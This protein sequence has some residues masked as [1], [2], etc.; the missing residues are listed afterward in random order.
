ML[1]GLLTLPV[2]ARLLVLGVG[3]P[4][5]R[6]DGA[7]PEWVAPAGR[8][9]RLPSA[10]RS[11]RHETLPV[12]Q[13]GEPLLASPEALEVPVVPVTR[14]ART[15]GGGMQTIG[16]K[17]VVA[18]QRDRVQLLSAAVVTLAILA[19]LTSWGVLDLGSAAAE[20]A[21]II[22]GSGAD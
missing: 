15:P 20:P 6:V 12:V 3:Q 2:Y 19:V 18:A 5:S 22:I 13:E 16:S 21:P 7:A 9:W 8:T 17:A 14:A 11:P 4:T 1:A 10:R